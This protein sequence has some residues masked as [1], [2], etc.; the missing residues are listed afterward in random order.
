MYNIIVNSD[1]R[2]PVNK[3]LIHSTVLEVLQRYHVNSALEIGVS[4]VGDRKMHAINKQYRGIDDTTNIITFALEDPMPQA[5]AHFPKTGFIAAPDNVLR[6]GDIVLSYPQV[7]EDAR[8]DGVSV[9]EEFRVLV[10]HG[11]KHL[12]GYHHE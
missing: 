10:E 9:D 7:I 12:L 3:S 2:Y 6:L 1:Q 11:V 8:F 5:L 4:V